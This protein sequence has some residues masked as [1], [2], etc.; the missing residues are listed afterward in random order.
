[1]ITS[2][3]SLLRSPGPA[4]AA[5]VLVALAVR[6]YDLGTE[7]IWRDEAYS[8]AMAARPPLHIVSL[9]ARE[10]TTPPLYYLA[11]HSWLKV[12]GESANAAR[13]PSVIAGTLAV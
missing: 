10:D 12:F 4:L 11:L 2:F 6:L 5:I 3:R 1:M 9:T 7:S 8:I 13:M